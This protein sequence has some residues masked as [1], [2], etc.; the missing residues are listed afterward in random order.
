[1]QPQAMP[2]Q[3]APVRGW[4]PEGSIHIAGPGH[5][6]DCFLTTSDNGRASVVA[7]AFNATKHVHHFG[8]ATES[9]AREWI[10]EFGQKTEQ[11]AQRRAERK[12]ERAA[13]H[14]LQVGD[15]LSSSWGYDQTNTYFYEVT[16]VIGRRMV[17]L[18]P[19]AQ[20]RQETNFMAGTCVPVP[21]SYAGDPMRCLASETYASIPKTGRRASRIDP[22][23]TV[24]GV[25]VY[26]PHYWSS[27]A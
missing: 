19:L 25:R 27:Y 15:V 10:A 20:E 8:F 9:R 23:Q 17:E 26:R 3:V 21:G 6:W 4:I 7:Y 14:A 1:M 5:I 13:A 22:V 16:R 11:A 12:A 24:A 18:R 2:R